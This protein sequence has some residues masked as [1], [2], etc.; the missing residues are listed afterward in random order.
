MPHR[1]KCVAEP[2]TTHTLRFSQTK[3]ASLAPSRPRGSNASWIVIGTAHTCAVA[4]G[5]SACTARLGSRRTAL[6]MSRSP[7]GGRVIERRAEMPL[8]A[9]THAI[10]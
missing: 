4:E 5:V 6:G 2:H 10:T 8:C 7:A 9:A 3:Y 1:R